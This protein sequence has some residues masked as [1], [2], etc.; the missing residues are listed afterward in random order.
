MDWSWLTTSLAQSPFPTARRTGANVESVTESRFRRTFS[1]FPPART[2]RTNRGSLKRARAASWSGSD[3]GGIGACVSQSASPRGEIKT[4][5]SLPRNC[6]GRTC[7]TS[8]PSHF[9]EVLRDGT[10]IRR[11]RRSKRRQHRS[12]IFPS[13]EWSAATI[14]SSVVAT[15]ETIW[16]IVRNTGCWASS[17]CPRRE[18][19]RPILRPDGIPRGQKNSRGPSHRAADPGDC[20]GTRSVRTAPCSAQACSQH[21]IRTARSRRCRGAVRRHSDQSASS[22]GR[23][24]ASSTWNAPTSTGGTHS[25]ASRSLSCDGVTGVPVMAKRGP[26]CSAACVC[27]KKKG[28]QISRPSIVYLPATWVNRSVL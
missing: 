5:H 4:G 13:E 3:E 11:S 12:L 10:T 27:A 26:R 24:L 15:P 9:P 21:S 25:S 14:T 23:R 19:T 6:P 28:G 1:R 20:D 2:D 17:A 7:S 8:R 18:A 16:R 22:P